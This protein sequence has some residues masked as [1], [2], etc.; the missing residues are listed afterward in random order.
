M[1]QQ[2]MVRIHSQLVV[3]QAGKRRLHVL[4]EDDFAIFFDA[5][6]FKNEAIANFELMLFG[7]G[8]YQAFNADIIW[9]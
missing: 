8:S 3:L 6:W 4:L 1:T 2:S 7:L 9:I 5:R